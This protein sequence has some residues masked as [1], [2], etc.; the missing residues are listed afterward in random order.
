M[1]DGLVLL[2]FAPRNARGLIVLSNLIGGHQMADLAS[3]TRG[4]SRAWRPLLSSNEIRFGGADR[5]QFTEPTTLVLEAA[6]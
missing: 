5:P 3:L 1:E 2:R 4:E 6:Q